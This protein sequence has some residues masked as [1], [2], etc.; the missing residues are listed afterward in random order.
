MVL[1]TLWRLQS[2]C[3]VFSGACWIKK[4]CFFP[5]LD[6]TASTCSF[7]TPSIST[8]I[9]STSSTSPIIIIRHKDAPLAYF[10]HFKQVQMWAFSWD[11]KSGVKVVVAISDVDLIVGGG[12]HTATLWWN[13]FLLWTPNW[14][15]FST[16]H[17]REMAK[18]SWI[19]YLRPAKYHAIRAS[20]ALQILILVTKSTNTSVYPI[21]LI[22]S[23]WKSEWNFWQ[24]CCV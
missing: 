3:V 14:W 8:L 18:S 20:W 15:A 17:M 12:L 5:S 1:K 21:T 16:V 13:F 19:S 24:I 9:Y 2:N 10:Q 6:K 22:L 23:A 11:S 4:T 7:A